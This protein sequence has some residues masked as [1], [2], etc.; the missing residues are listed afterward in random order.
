MRK[1][2]PKGKQD[3]IA[4]IL[5]LQL[6]KLYH[7]LLLHKYANKLNVLISHHKLKSHIWRRFCDILGES[8][9]SKEPISK[10]FSVRLGNL[11]CKTVQN[12]DELRPAQFRGE[13]PCLGLIWKKRKCQCVKV[14]FWPQGLF[15][16][17]DLPCGW[18]GVKAWQGIVWMSCIFPITTVRRFPPKNKKRG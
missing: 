11:V 12:L 9:L 15:D 17:T 2:K 4:A 6:T 14:R 1:I 13:R 16:K 10:P 5:S 7:L 8:V 18:Y 3:W